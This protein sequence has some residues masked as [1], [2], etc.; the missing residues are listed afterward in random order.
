VAASRHV[1]WRTSIVGSPLPGPASA[2]APKLRTEDEAIAWLGAERAN[3]HACVGY[4]AS[5]GRLVHAVRIP[6]AVSDFLLTEG[7]WNEAASLGQVAWPLR[8]RPA[9]GRAKPGPFTSWALWS[10]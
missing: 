1:A 9:T 6:V 7:H 5:H 8:T 10:S 3:L 2:W 4:A